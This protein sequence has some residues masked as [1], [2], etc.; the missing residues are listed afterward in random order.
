MI[1]VGIKGER[2]IFELLGF[3]LF[4]RSHSVMMSV[5]LRRRKKQTN[6]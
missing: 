4:L 6:N 3:N 1:S 2:K 5:Y